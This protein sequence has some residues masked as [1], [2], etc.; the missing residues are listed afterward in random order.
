MARPKKEIDRKTFEGLCGIQCTMEE[1]CDVF[2]ISEK[3]LTAWCKRTYG[4]SFSQVFSKKR[5]VGKISLRRAGFDLAKRNAAVHIFYAK[6]FLGMSDNIEIVDATALEKI[7][8][9]L[10]GIEVIADE[11]EQET[12]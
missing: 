5:N 6:N 12:S 10:E 7:D 8:K 4:L 3:T 1:I 9:V 2:D 11:A